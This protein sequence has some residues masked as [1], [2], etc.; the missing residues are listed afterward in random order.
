MRIT[1]LEVAAYLH[2]TGYKLTGTE[3]DGRRMVFDFEATE[4]DLLGYVNG[5]AM[6]N[7]Y[8]LYSS[9]RAMKALT[10]QP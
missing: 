1:D 7:A 2:A 9:F 5:E 6:V 4:E 10:R 3:R 8:A